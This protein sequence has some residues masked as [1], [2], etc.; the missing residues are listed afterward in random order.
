MTR[1]VYINNTSAYLP[2][3]AV[4]NKQMES[5]LGLAGGKPSKTRRLILRSNGIKQRYYAI[6]PETNAITHTSAQLSAEAIRGLKCEE[7]ELD[8]ISC[9]VAASSTPD[10]IMPNHAVMVHGELDV[11]DIE[12]VAT[13]GVCVCG[14]TALKYAY[15]SVLTGE[16]G[17]VVAAASELAS[18]LMH[19]RNFESE[20]ELK[21]QTLDARPELAF[22]KDFLR[23]MLSDAGGA[24]WLSD[25]PR[26]NNL[27][28]RVE[29]IDLTSYAHEVEVCMYSGSEKVEGQLKGWTQYTGQERES[30]SVFALKQDVKLLNEKIVP[31]LIEKALSKVVQKYQLQV[32]DIDYFLPHYSSEFFRDKVTIGLRNI[33][34]DI[35]QEKWFTNLTSK[36]NTGAASI[37]VMLD[38]LYKSGRLKKGDK[39]LCFVPESGRF[40]VAYMLLTVC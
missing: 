18:A 30:R 37:Y 29:W 28:L 21:K 4:S 40:S 14:M 16:H 34:F 25:T 19:A 6:D 24:A 32:S 7:F 36:G 35:P 12:V 2:N 33:D 8:K 9:L 22:E 26:K 39:L 20:L 15:M 3:E 38:E 5:L 11:K 23:W 27:S 13:S 31:Y 17:N 10:Q 1:A